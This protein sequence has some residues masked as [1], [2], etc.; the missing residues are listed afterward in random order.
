MYNFVKEF[1]R[2]KS[3]LILTSARPA[4]LVLAS[5]LDLA[6]NIPVGYDGCLGTP[7]FWSTLAYFGLQ[8]CFR[9]VARRFLC[10]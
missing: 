8:F 2:R 4:L 1:S 9:L 3:L 10:V 6:L 5:S 7:S